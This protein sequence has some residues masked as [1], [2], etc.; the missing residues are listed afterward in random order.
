MDEQ[1]ELPLEWAKHAEYSREVRKGPTEEK[2][3]SHHAET[4]ED[5]TNLIDGLRDVYAARDE[6]SGSTTRC[7]KTVAGFTALRLEGSCG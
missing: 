7:Q 2:V 6:V 3:R 4:L 5:A 1:L